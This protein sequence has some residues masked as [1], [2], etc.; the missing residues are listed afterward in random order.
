MYFFF[1]YKKIYYKKGISTK[2][3]IIGA[4]CFQATSQI[5]MQEKMVISIQTSENTCYKHIKKVTC[6]VDKSSRP[7]W[8]IL[9]STTV[10]TKVLTLELRGALKFKR[11]RIEKTMLNWRAANFE[12][13]EGFTNIRTRWTQGSNPEVRKRRTMETIQDTK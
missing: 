6:E 3:D 7:F 12:L 10:Q 13:G 8:L 2:K 5:T 9:L 1:V 4:Q 11:K